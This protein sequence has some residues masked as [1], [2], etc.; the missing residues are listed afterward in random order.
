MRNIPEFNPRRQGR[1][2]QRETV[3][4]ESGQ[5]PLLSSYLAFKEEYDK[6]E[7][8]LRKLLNE[9]IQKLEKL[10][11]IAE[12]SKLHLADMSDEDIGEDDVDNED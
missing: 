12:Q 5:T 6:M 2:L 9:Q 4:L 3:E 8:T 10:I 11:I 1:P 7:E